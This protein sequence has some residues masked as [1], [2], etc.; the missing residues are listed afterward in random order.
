VT[1]GA[2]GEGLTLTK[3][4]YSVFLQRSF[5]LIKNLQAEDRTWRKGQMREVQRIDIM[6]KDTIE[7]HIL[8]VGFDRE[9]KLQELCRDE[10][11]VKRWLLKKK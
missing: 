7:D 3:A 11:T 8:D 9:D 6:A 4:R 5:S 1:L 2:G 10:E